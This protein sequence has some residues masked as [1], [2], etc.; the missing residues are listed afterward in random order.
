MIEAKAATPSPQSRSQPQPIS[1]DSSAGIL[2][3]LIL[4]VKWNG[5]GH[6]RSTGIHPC[7]RCTAHAHADPRTDGRTLV[8]SPCGGCFP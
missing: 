8:R 2:G 4:Y 7:R 1:S 3:D 5:G 6:H